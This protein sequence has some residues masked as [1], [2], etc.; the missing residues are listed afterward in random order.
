[1]YADYGTLTCGGYPGVLNHQEMDAKTFAEWGVDQVKLDGC[2]VEATS[3]DKGLMLL[4]SLENSAICI[5]IILLYYRPI[6]SI[7]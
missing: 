3:M 5:P 7:S 6:D 1:M 2:Y 4:Y